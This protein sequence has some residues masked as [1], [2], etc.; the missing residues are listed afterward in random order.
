MRISLGRRR[1]LSAPLAG[2]VGLVVAGWLGPRTLL[3]ADEVADWPTVTGE[4]V[5]SHV[6][7]RTGRRG[8]GDS[9]H[10][11]I[12]YR[13]PV[14]GEVLEGERWDVAGPRKLPGQAAAE[15]VVRAFPAGA[16]VE[17][18]FDP[19]DPSSAVLAEGGRLHGWLLVAFGLALVA[20][21]GA[22]VLKRLVL[23]RS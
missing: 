17:V 13:Y 1:R 8:S 16:E 23:G 6:E 5:S 3:E 18:H 2:V 20:Y 22:G 14:D 12:R 19:D 11:V 4:V 21:A 10:A 15:E 9:W 7:R